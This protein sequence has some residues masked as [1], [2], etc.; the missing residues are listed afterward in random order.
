MGKLTKRQDLLCQ[1]DI[2]A[3]LPT[4]LDNLGIDYTEND[5]CYQMSCP[6]HSGRK[7]SAVIIYKNSGYFSCFTGDCNSKYGNSLF[8]F[9]RGCLTAKNDGQYPVYN[10]TV[11]AGYTSNFIRSLVNVKSQTQKE[12][13]CLKSRS[14]NIKKGKISRDVVRSSLVIPSPYYLKRGFSAE[15]LDEYDVGDSTTT[16]TKKPMYKRVVI[17]IYDEEKNMIGCSGRAIYEDWEPKWRN[18]NFQ[19]SQTLFNYWRAAPH[20]KKSG[21]VIL[22]EGPGNVLR[23]EEAGIHNSLAMFGKDI[24]DAHQFLLERLG[25]MTIKIC[26]DDDEAGHK[27]RDKIIRNCSSLYNI[28]VAKFVGN[29]VGELSV[30]QVKEI[31][32][33]NPN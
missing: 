17:P 9:V 23:F 31:E 1:D 8:G 18:F 5:N 26:L 30:D 22:V 2:L 13:D 7:Q 3:G 27:G 19:K 25:V 12:V 20:I 24:S 28:K 15:I 29:D 32:W 10:G 21:E 16:N 4:I 6:I 33:T 11:L 14:V